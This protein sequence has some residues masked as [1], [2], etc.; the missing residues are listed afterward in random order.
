MYENDFKLKSWMCTLI[1]S[2]LSDSEFYTDEQ[3]GNCKKNETV[4]NII[5]GTLCWHFVSQNASKSVDEPTS[6]V[7]R[8]SLIGS[9]SSLIACCG[10]CNPKIRKKIFFSDTGSDYMMEKNQMNHEKLFHAL[11]WCLLRK[12]RMAMDFF[13]KFYAPLSRENNLCYNEITSRYHEITVHKKW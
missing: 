11:E 7:L 6:D 2:E 4:P 9:L 8:F 12:P 3:R 13:K 10:F 5:D 1:T